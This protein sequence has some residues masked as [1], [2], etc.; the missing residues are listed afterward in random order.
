MLT[1]T[2]SRYQ[3]RSLFC[4]ALVWSLMSPLGQVH[5]NHRDSHASALHRQVPRL[6]HIMGIRVGLD[7]LSVLERKL[8]KGKE[9]TGGHPH[10]ARLWRS[11]ETGWIIYADSF[12]GPVDV[13]RVFG[14]SQSPVS[15]TTIPRVN[16]SRASL[17]F[18]SR[19]RLGMSRPQVFH[20]MRDSL[21]TP[22]ITANA[23]VWKVIGDVKLTKFAQYRTWFAELTFSH[24]HLDQI[25]IYCQ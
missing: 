5:Q 20:I 3:Y 23:V 6:A 21:P 4:L 14:A 19:V 13:L 10:G 11:K 1:R 7:S 17:G 22:K 9:I 8:G 16:A 25:S 12:D 24:G 2:D 15:L 18:W